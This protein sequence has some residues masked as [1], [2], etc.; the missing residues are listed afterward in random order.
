MPMSWGWG[1]AHGR[2]ASMECQQEQERPCPHLALRIVGCAASSS[3]QQQQH[4]WWTPCWSSLGGEFAGDHYASCMLMCAGTQLFSSHS[5][6]KGA[7]AFTHC[8]IRCHVLHIHSHAMLQ[9]GQHIAQAPVV[10][11]MGCGCQASHAVAAV[12][13]AYASSLCGGGVGGVGRHIMA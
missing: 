9:Y 10:A 5:W 2:W 12:L 3:L 11:W 1:G 6:R 4:S 7:Q 13:E 8:S